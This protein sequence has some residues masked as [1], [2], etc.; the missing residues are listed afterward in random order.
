MPHKVCTIC[1]KWKIERLFILQ[2]KN[3]YN[4]RTPIHQRGEQTLNKQAKTN[5]E[6]KGVAANTNAVAN[7]SYQAENLSCLH[8]MCN[9]TTASN[10]YKQIRP[11][12]ILRS[13]DMV[14]KV[15]TTSKNH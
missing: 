11:S 5:G 12:Y 2:G 7:W 9:L 8:K 6:I 14:F 10:I 3:R 4:I 15:T 1:I 13:E